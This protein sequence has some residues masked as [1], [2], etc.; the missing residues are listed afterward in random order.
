[1]SAIKRIGFK[2]SKGI[3]DCLQCGRP[4]IK[5]Y[6]GARRIE[7]PKCGTVNLIGT[8]EAGH[9]VVTDEKHAARFMNRKEEDNDTDDTS[10]KQPGSKA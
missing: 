2:S 4:L 5:L 3:L 6:T 10:E 8:T 9:I 7:C 1:M